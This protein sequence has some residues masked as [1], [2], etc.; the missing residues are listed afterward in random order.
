MEKVSGNGYVDCRILQ[1]NPRPSGVKV[2]LRGD[3]TPFENFWFTVMNLGWMQKIN[4]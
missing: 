4:M 1:Q 3:R 2:A